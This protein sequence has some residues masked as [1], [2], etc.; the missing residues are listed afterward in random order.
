MRST[1]L[2]SADHCPILECSSSLGCKE[3]ESIPSRLLVVW[4]R[5][6]QLCALGFRVGV[7]LASWGFGPPGRPTWLFWSCEWVLWRSL[8]PE[9]HTVIEPTARQMPRQENFPWNSWLRMTRGKVSHGNILLPAHQF[10]PSTS[11]FLWGD[12][13]ACLSCFHKGWG[14]SLQ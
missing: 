10:P 13:F 8:L 11:P 1:L 7:T 4:N 9:C 6:W 2:P 12:L 3:N 5:K 14:Q